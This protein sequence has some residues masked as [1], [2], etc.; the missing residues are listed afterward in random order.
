MLSSVAGTGRFR[1]DCLGAVRVVALR[2][3]RVSTKGPFKEGSG[4]GFGF[5]VQWCGKM[6][7]GGDRVL[8]L[9]RLG[10]GCGILDFVMFASGETAC[11]GVCD[12]G[13]ELM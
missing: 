7:S 1:Y 12:E 3:E 5:R 6:G 11:F 10:S 4:F 2:V 13:L 9:G 8:A